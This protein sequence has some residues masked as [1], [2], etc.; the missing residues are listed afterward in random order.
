MSRAVGLIDGKPF[1]V[2]TAGAS[3]GRLLHPGLTAVGRTPQV[4]TEKR[5]V[6]PGGLQTEIEEVAHL[7]GFGDRVAPENSILENTGEGPVYASISRITPAALPEIGSNIIELPPADR[8]A[9]AVRWVNGNHTFVRS[10]AEDILAV[11][12]DVRLVTDE[13]VIH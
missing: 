13:P 10:V 6:W 11:L 1:L 12:I 2:A 3:V 4:V 9:V 5:L 8:H 7:V